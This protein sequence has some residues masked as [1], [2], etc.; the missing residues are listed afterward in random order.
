[1]ESNNHLIGY[2]AFYS[3]NA[4][5]AKNLD[6]YCFISFYIKQICFLCQYFHFG[7]CNKATKYKNITE[8]Y[9]CPNLFGCKVADT[10]GQTY[11]DRRIIQSYTE[12]CSNYF[13]E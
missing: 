2:S 13:G 3:G 1:M 11:M 5:G 12:E 4:K 9:D 8:C 10:W 7:K 6:C